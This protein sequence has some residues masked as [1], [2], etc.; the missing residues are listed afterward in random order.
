[1]IG[2][3]DQTLVGAVSSGE[4][5][6]I[7]RLIAGAWPDFVVEPADGTEVFKGGD[8]RT[9]LWTVPCEL[10]VYDS[11]AAYE[12]WTTDGLTDDNAAR[13]ISINAEA[14]AISFV[15]DAPGSE[16]GRHVSMLIE[17]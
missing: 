14:D 9:R 4:I 11:R 13:M 2:G 16:T 5:A 15:V 8:D 3:F 12:S 7:L 1:M 10:F 17:A 6:Q